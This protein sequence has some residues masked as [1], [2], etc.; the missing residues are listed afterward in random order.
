MVTRNV[1]ACGS[2]GSCGNFEQGG[3]AVATRWR[4]RKETGRLAKKQDDRGDNKTELSSVFTSERKAGDWLSHPPKYHVMHVINP[5]VCFCVC[6]VVSLVCVS[7]VSNDIQLDPGGALWRVF[8]LH[9]NSDAGCRSTPNLIGCDLRTQPHLI[10]CITLY[11]GGF[12]PAAA[13][14]GCW[15]RAARVRAIPTA[16]DQPAKPDNATSKRD[17][18]SESS[19]VEPPSPPARDSRLQVERN[20]PPA[21]SLPSSPVSVIYLFQ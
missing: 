4:Q 13:A 1:S 7:L 15:G 6:L 16:L 2:P 5:A 19:R 18:S 12:A 10:M 14:P 8:T 20:I 11:L 9:P 17:E 3:R 21:L